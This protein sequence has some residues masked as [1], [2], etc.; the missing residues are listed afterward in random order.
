MPGGRRSVQTPLSSE[1][2]CCTSLPLRKADTRTPATGLPPAVSVPVTELPV[3]VAIAGAVVGVVGVV[4]AAAA[5][6]APNR[7]A[8]R[9]PRM[10]A[11]TSSVTRRVVPWALG[12]ATPVV[13]GDG[14]A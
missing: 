14:E 7:P 8:T 1:R 11:R 4:G 13:G 12:N 5:R 9:A 2:V 3:G 10:T 6:P